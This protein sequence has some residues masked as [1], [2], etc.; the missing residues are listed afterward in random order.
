MKAVALAA[1][2][3]ELCVATR[4][5]RPTASFEFLVEPLPEIQSLLAFL[6]GVEFRQLLRLP[7]R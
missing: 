6:K 3:C 1:C 7:E 2:L 5:Q 4:S